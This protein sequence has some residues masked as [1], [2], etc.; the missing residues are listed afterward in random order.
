MFCAKPVLTKNGRTTL[1]WHV[2]HRIIF[3]IRCECINWFF[4]LDFKVSSKLLTGDME[5][6][7]H[8]ASVF[9]DQFPF[10]PPPDSI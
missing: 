2:F 9:L 10:H 5:K 4:L 1:V 3:M 8:P 7:F 6:G